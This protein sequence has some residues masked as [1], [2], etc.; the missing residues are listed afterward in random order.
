M[1]VDRLTPLGAI[2]LLGP[3]SETLYT[4][5]A[6]SGAETL[7]LA[8][9]NVFNLTLTGAVTLTFANPVPAGQAQSFVLILRQD[10]TGGRAVTWPAS[11]DWPAAIP[12]SIS[13]GANKVDILVFT[14]I[15]GGVTWLGQVASMDV[16]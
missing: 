14:T 6:A 15:D 9:A 12:P 10:A 1:A 2:G 16:R 5:A 7:D 13:T 11:V 4:D 8:V 3:Y